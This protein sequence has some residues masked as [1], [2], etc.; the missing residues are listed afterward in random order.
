MKYNQPCMLPAQH[1]L[2]ALAPRRATLGKAGIPRGLS[3]P[4][5]LVPDETS[6]QLRVS[7]PGPTVPFKPSPTCSL[8]KWKT[9]SPKPLLPTEEE[10]QEGAKRL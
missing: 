8:P 4:E 9:H 1:H 6:R 7:F 5:S 2:P 10:K 3:F